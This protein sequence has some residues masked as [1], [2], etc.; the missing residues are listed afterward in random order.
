[1]LQSERWYNT[2]D[3]A[4]RLDKTSKLGV[5]PPHFFFG[6][7]IEKQSCHLSHLARSSGVPSNL[8]LILWIASKP[9]DVGGDDQRSARLSP[10]VAL[11]FTVLW[12][13]EI[14]RVAIE[15]D[16]W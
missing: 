14:G 12:H 15:G 2:S 16:L 11:T 9:A 10:L 6:L 3:Q 1:M 7:G 4:R 5:F 8:K 13:L